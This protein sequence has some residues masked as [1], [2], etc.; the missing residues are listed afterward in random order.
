LRASVQAGLNALERGEFS[1]IDESEL[2]AAL[3][4]LAPNPVA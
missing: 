2:D 4:A 1:D 3:D